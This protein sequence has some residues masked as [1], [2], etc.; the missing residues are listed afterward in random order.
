MQIV[1]SGIISR[2]PEL[3]AYMPSIAPLADGTWVAVQ[4]VGQSLGS[5]DN[6]IESLVSRDQG[7][8]WGN[9]GSIHGGEGPDDR[10]TY[11]APKI[12]TVPDGRLLISADRYQ[13][14]QGELFDLESETLARSEMLLIWSEDG[15]QSWSEP[16]VIP[17]DLPPEKYSWNGTGPVLQVRPDRWIYT[18]ETWKPEGYSGPPDQKSAALISTD[19]GQTWG[20]LTVTANDPQHKLMYYDQLGAVLPDGRICIL[21]WTHV[22]GTSEDLNNHWVVSSDDGRS[23]SAPKPTN[24]RGQVC[25]PIAL[26]DGRVAAVYNFRHQ[27]QGVRLALSEDLEQFDLE[28]EL[29]LFDAGAEASMGPPATDSFHAEHMQIAFGK[30]GG[31]QLPDGDLLTYFWCTSE[32]ITHTRW[33]RIGLA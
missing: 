24:L 14:H 10:F 26:S 7:A 16:Q 27:P 1:D 32:G 25:A 18:L 21:L 33:V 28:H 3:G 15:G 9:R 20:E 12:V 22:D 4:H 30:P 11:R 31:L 8:T 2:R 17:V 13:L 6:H 29:V 19:A 5:A 23:W